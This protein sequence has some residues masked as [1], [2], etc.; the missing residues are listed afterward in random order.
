[1]NF[2][3]K[4]ISIPAVL[5]LIFIISSGV[6]TLGYKI[7]MNKFNNLVSFS[8]EKQKMY[9]DLGEID[10][11]IRNEYI[12]DVQES[13]I[14]SN[15]YFG[16]IT[17]VHDINC[18][19]FI[20]EDY[21][22]YLQNK[23]LNYNKIKFELLDNNIGYLK[24]PSFTKNSSDDFIQSINSLKNQE[25]SKVIIDLRNNSDGDIE[26]VFKILKYLIPNSKLVYSVTKDNSKELACESHSDNNINM[27]FSVIINNNTSGASE[28]L[29]SVLRDNL[30]SQLIGEQSAGNP[31]REKITEISDN[32]VIIFPDAV[33]VTSKDTNFYKIGLVPDENLIMKNE[34]KDL[35]LDNNLPYSEDEH[36]EIAINLLNI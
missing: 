31:V 30:N 13:Q 19:I 10:Y 12:G 11:I 14:L 8:Q 5:V 18:K 29:A 4:K 32:H 15:L 22:S 6:Y 3:N 16:Y 24:C 17:G 34:H 36:L 25:I 23:K 2:F 21:E 27:N 28:I 26:E 7:A 1:M 9:G 35:L 20:K 33:Y